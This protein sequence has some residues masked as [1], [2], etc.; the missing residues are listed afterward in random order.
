[1]KLFKKE[2]AIFTVVGKNGETIR[3][4][5][6][7]DCQDFIK[8]EEITGEMLKDNQDFGYTRVDGEKYYTVIPTGRREVINKENVALVTGIGILVAGGLISWFKKKK[9]KE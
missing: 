2:E 1:M 5:S 7:E 8:A 9:K 3:R 4:G 6:L